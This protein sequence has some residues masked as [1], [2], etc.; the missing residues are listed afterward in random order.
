M[1]T[2][3]RKGEDEVAGNAR[4]AG[5]LDIHNRTENWKTARHLAP[6]FGDAAIRLAEHL[7][8]PLQSGGQDVRLELY[9]KGM[10]DFLH[11]ENDKEKWKVEIGECYRKLFG[12]LRDWVIG[13]DGFQALKEHNYDPSEAEGLYRNQY[14]TEI[15]IVLE[16]PRALFIGE[17]KGEMSFGADSGLVLVHQLIRQY[18]MATILVDLTKTEKR[19]VPF[20]VGGNEKQRQVQ[21]M[22]E[23]G[24]ME[25]GHVLSWSTIKR[26]AP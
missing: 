18:V 5:I 25:E 9:W 12:N 4:R 6:F 15:D 3:E 24:W 17:A 10:R 20:V 13:F 26:L 7:D 19:V 16:S 14:H 21:F 2:L 22:I 23:R 8:G 11:G 1:N